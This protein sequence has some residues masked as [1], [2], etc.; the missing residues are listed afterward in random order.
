MAL[1]DTGMNAQV[2]PQGHALVSLLDATPQF[3][4]QLLLQTFG[5]GQD[6]LCIRCLCL[7][8]HTCNPL[9]PTCQD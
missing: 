5:I 7:V 3:L 8:R 9:M 6:L 1:H 2:T 4:V